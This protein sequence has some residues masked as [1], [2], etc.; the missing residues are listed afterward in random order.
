MFSLSLVKI[1]HHQ[2]A[3]KGQSLAAILKS[4]LP[5]EQNFTDPNL[6]VFLDGRIVNLKAPNPEKPRVSID[7]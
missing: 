6:T 7:F 2:I 5:V 1:G 4:T 3:K